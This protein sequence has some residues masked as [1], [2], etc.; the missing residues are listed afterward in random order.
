L[1]PPKISATLSLKLGWY[2]IENAA[3]AF[4]HNANDT[5]F[6]KKYQE[7]SMSVAQIKKI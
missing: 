4:S 2:H 1:I 6:Q 7:P 5:D 3:G